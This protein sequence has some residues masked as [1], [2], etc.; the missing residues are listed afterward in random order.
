MPAKH[1]Y[2][3]AICCET[4]FVDGAA[5]T[6]KAAPGVLYWLS[7]SNANA[8]AQLFEVND[9][10]TAVHTSELMIFTVPL[11]GHIHCVFDPPVSCAIGIRIGVCHTDINVMVGYA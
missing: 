4:A 1:N 2:Q 9:V 5:T 3:D 7:A 8:A 6:V 10:A 11:G